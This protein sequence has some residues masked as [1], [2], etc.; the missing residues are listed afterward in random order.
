MPPDIISWLEKKDIATVRILK[1]YPIIWQLLLLFAII[2]IVLYFIFVSPPV[3]FGADTRFTVE[4]GLTLSQVSKKLYD[5][6]LIKSQTLFEIIVITLEGEGG[7]R[8][9]EYLFKKPE[10]AWSIARRITSADF[11]IIPVS[12][13]IPEG[14]TVVGMADIFATHLTAFNKD[15]FIRIAKKD[16]GYLFPDTYKFFPNDGELKAYRTLREN[17]DEKIKA[18]E[19]NLLQSGKSLKDIIIMAS[20]LEKEARTM[21]TRRTIAGILWKRLELDMPLQ[22]DAVFE[23]IIDKNTYTLT[24]EDLQIDS[25]YNTYKYK[26]LPVGPIANPGLDSIRAALTPIE[27]PYFYYLSDKEGNIYYSRTFHEH[28]AKKARYLK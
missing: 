5:R 15:V 27:S 25:P 14:T 17:F 19:Q 8:H 4:E 23:Y 2:I 24:T 16:E 28:V 3:S 6:G 22:V 21:E 13:V 26:G 10:S 12:I 11:R 9:G 20:L 1:R 18:V 7:V